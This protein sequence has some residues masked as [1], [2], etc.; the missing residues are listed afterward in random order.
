MN[1]VKIRKLKQEDVKSLDR[2]YYHFW[3]EQ[4]NIQLMNEKFS[5]LS[6]NDSY[7]FL[8]VEV[9]NV[10]AGSILGI[11]CHELYGN[12][13]PFLLMEDLIVD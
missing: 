2:L 3:N 10:I 12:C 13:R 6:N 9:D 7:I 5:K 11:V 1:K 8:V 4:S